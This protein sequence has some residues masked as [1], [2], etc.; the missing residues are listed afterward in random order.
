[1]AQ[2][3]NYNNEKHVLKRIKKAGKILGITLLTTAT[4]AMGSLGINIYKGMHPTKEQTSY[5]Q[6]T[7]YNEVINDHI[8]T[9]VYN[10]F[11]TY[12]EE[13]P[14]ISIRLSNYDYMNILDSLNSQSNNYRMSEYYG[15]DQAIDMYNNTQVNK[16]T[17]TSLLTNGR[18]DTSKLIQ[19]VQKN[20][21]AVTENGKNTLNAFYQDLSTSEISM[22]CEKI[23]EV[24][25][26]KS[27]EINIKELA[28]TLERL[29]MFKRTGTTSSAYISTDLTFIYNPIATKSNETI[30]EITNQDYEGGLE[31]VI[32]HEIMHLIQYSSNDN[33]NDNGIEAGFCRMYN[34]PSGDKKIPVDSLWCPWLLEGSA[35]LGMANYLNIEPGTYQKKISYIKSYNLAHFNENI[36][37]ENSLEN[38]V[39]NP[40]LEEAF[41]DLGLETENEK[42]DFLNYMYSIEITQ[43]DPKDFWEYYESKTGNKPTDEEKTGIR[44]DIRTDAVKHLTISFFENLTEAINEGKITDLNTAFYLM[45]TWELDTYNH[46]E[47]TQTSSFEHAK[48]FITWYDQTQNTILTAIAQ[49]SNLD[50]TEVTTMYS[51]YNL[52]VEMEDGSVKDNCDLSNF[53]GYMQY[54]IAAAKDDYKTSNFSRISDVATKI[55]SEKTTTNSNQH[56]K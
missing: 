37:R 11:N 28:N 8:G 52:Q 19:V 42:Q 41:Q 23:A 10:E 44:M 3:Y 53:N 9:T 22:L 34:T 45:R 1:M 17:D 16:S 48:D 47:Y 20:N 27:N 21:S 7:T 32:D 12:D 38:A 5:Y 51:D 24:V 6:N 33:N 13:T 54:Y 18:L 30:K 29:T 4:I 56:K 40:T 39:F 2:T 55:N 36:A 26:N 25:N 50:P 14:K 46:L 35:E 49:S 43:S 31:A 15:L